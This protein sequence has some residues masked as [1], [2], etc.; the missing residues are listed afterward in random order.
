MKNKF[1]LFTLLFFISVFYSKAQNYEMSAYANNSVITT[2]KGTFT[3]TGGYYGVGGYGN[4][5]NKTITFCSGT[6]GVP[7]RISFID[8]DVESGYDFIRIYDGTGTGGTL[9][10]TITGTDE[11]FSANSS[12]SFYTSTGTC[13]TVQFTSDVSIT[14]FGWDALIGCAPQNCGNNSPANNSC[15]AAPQICDLNG[16][17]GNTSGWYT[18]DNGQ[19]DNTSSG[20]GLFC[21]SIENNSWISF[22]A[23]ATTATLNVNSS[24][25]AVA[26]SGI[27][28]EVFETTNCSSFTSKS[29]CV[30]QNTGSGNFTLTAT[31]LTVGTKYYVMIDGY[32]GNIC[33]YTVTANTGV[34]V[35]TLTSNPTNATICRGQTATISVNNAPT[36][37]TY[38]W[39]PTGSIV[40]AS[41]GATITVNP[42]TTTTYSCTITLPNGCGT[43]I[44][45]YTITVNQPTTPTFTQLGAYC[46]G[47]TP[48]TLL[49]TSSNGITGTWNPATISTATAGNSTYTFTPSA[50]NTCATTATMN[51]TVNNTINT[52]INREI[53][54]GQS[55]IIG[56][57]MFNETG[58]Y[59][60]ILQSSQGCD[61]IIHLNLTVNPT[62]NIERNEIICQ[63]QSISIG[64]QTF[65]E[66]GNYTVTLQTQAGCDSIIYLALTVNPTYD[67]QRT[68]SICAGQSITIGD[69]VFNETGNYTIEFRTTEGCD[70]II[71]LNLTVN[72]TYNIERN[73]IICQGQSI[74]IG[75]QTFNETGNYTVTLQTNS[76]CD[77]IVNL[78]LTVN[79][80][81]D[82]QRT[83]SICA[84]QSITIGTQTFNESG[85]YTVT[86]QTQAGCDSIINL[87]L[88][89]NPTYRM[90][91]SETICY[92]Q[93]ITIGS[94]TFN[95]TGNYTV[96]FQT[97]AG[98][99]SVINL[100][101]TVNPIYST[102]RSESICQGQSITIGSQTFNETG[103]YTVT[104]QTINGCDSIINLALTVNPI[105]VLNASVD[106][107]IINTGQTVQLNAQSDIPAT[108]NWQ[109]I[110]IV[111]NS[112]IANPTASPLSSTWFVVT[113]TA[114]ETQCVAI[115]SVLVTVNE[116]ECSKK[117]VFIPNAF[118]PN[119]DGVN[120]IF[121]PRSTIL[122]SMRLIV[123]DR[124][125]NQVFESNDLNVGWDGVYKNKLELEDSYGYYF[126]GECSQGGKI[127][128]KGNV[129]L[130][131]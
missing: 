16:Y 1:L 83:E 73:E 29:N 67:I 39:T 60:V 58:N 23:S 87:A 36:G 14:G 38:S 96:A 90:N 65:N 30:S 6:P 81:Y 41:N 116:L 45:N 54:Q 49:T 17:C 33:D 59:S 42:T 109:P 129:T 94:Q 31:G 75:T 101:L 25:C 10:G 9:L 123:F 74:T 70:S 121:I 97:Q 21:G 46:V 103:N 5:I 20:S 98:C 63:G 111:S 115:D 26:G 22:I 110:D 13:L 104:L 8:W 2:C 62:Y 35:I 77:S 120:D 102:L 72:P 34:Q 114:T 76:G 105:P 19:I 86:L 15:S 89:V 95:E 12:S 32:A 50:N 126:V 117:Y 61:S 66:T 118:T 11:I 7:I 127:I 64:T 91:R 78:A 119:N 57:E 112:T 4:N 18:R 106:T 48:G 100:A 85:N 52:N 69:L 124:W 55:I 92:G 131:R 122:K 93:N 43:Q 84:G 108:F 3:Y 113:A 68:E 130:M 37:T 128:I 125:G 24:N 107:S 40:G 79:P 47:A 82:L 99:D 28:A 80:T 53:C 88:T 44:E 51:V 71:H 27:Q 56:N